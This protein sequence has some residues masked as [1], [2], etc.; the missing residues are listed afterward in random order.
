MITLPPGC[1]V[2]YPITI[3]LEK[4]NDNMIQWFQE[5]GGNVKHDDYWDYRGRLVK[6]LYVSYG[7]GKWCHYHQNG[8]EQVRLHFNG[9]DGPV[10]TM[11][12]MTFLDQIASHNFREFQKENV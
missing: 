9:T 1:T 11:F 7:K 6:R 5:V 2:N 8:T 12:L 3:E 4:L 10:A